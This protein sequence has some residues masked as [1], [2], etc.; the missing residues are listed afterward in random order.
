M[1]GPGSPRSGLLAQFEA[2]L[3]PLDPFGKPVDPRRLLGIGNVLLSRVQLDVAKPPRMLAL[4]VLD[5]AQITLHPTQ[6][7]KDQ[8]QV[9]HTEI[10]PCRGHWASYHRWQSDQRLRKE[11]AHGPARSE[12]AS[13]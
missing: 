4:G 9:G 6:H 1:I 10:V 12:A 8:F 2:R 7:F 5:V 3:Y 11:H 13:P